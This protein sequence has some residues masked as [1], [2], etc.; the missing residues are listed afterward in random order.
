MATATRAFEFVLVNS[1]SLARATSEPEAFRQ[2]FSEASQE[3]KIITF[4][5]LGND[6]L[7]V[8]PCPRDKSSVYS[9]LASFIREAPSA[10]KHA[11]WQ[12]VGK[13]LAQRLNQHPLWISTSG[14]GVSWLHIRLDSSPKYY[15]FNPYKMAPA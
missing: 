4:P 9:D 13:Q 1:P 14:L 5:N 11:L 3:E 8:V 15:K 10:Q 12:M 2:Y 7:L 6:A